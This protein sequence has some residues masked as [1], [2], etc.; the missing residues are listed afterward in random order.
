M[1]QQWRKGPTIMTDIVVR[2]FWVLK[3]GFMLFI[4]FQR[5]SIY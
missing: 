2:R 1:V 5:L 3:L 4:I